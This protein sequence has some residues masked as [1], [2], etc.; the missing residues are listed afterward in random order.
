M[1][2]T[3]LR[4]ALIAAFVIELLILAIYLRSVLAPIVVLFASRR[5]RPPPGQ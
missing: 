2:V 5:C 1:T 3:S 4:D